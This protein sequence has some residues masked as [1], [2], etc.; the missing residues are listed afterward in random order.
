MHEKFT[1]LKKLFSFLMAE[2]KSSMFGENLHN[3]MVALQWFIAY[4]Y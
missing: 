2:H 4:C 1:R 3:P